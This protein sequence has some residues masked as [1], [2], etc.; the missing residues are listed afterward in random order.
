MSV[1]TPLL[2]PCAR[3]P[4]ADAW[5]AS[6]Y[7]QH[8]ASRLRTLAALAGALPDQTPAQT[9]ARE[10]R[11]APLRVV[12]QIASLSDLHDASAVRSITSSSSPRRAT[13]P[14]QLGHDHF[15]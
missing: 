13:K 7:D 15:R 1:S 14:V 5:S 10:S 9:P 2:A 11:A 4:G 8:H 12:S 3:F 6:V